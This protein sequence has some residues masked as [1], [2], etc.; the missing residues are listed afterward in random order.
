ME[1]VKIVVFVGFHFNCVELSVSIEM[2]I[3]K[4][5]NSGTKIFQGKDKIISERN[6]CG[7]VEL[8]DFVSSFPDCAGVYKDCGLGIF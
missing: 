1:V 4:N 3:S 5:T 6:I 8:L 7:N 2:V